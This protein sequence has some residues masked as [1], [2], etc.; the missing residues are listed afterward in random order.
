MPGADPAGGGLA[1][2]SRLGLLP[3]NPGGL[4]A[5][6]VA[7]VAWLGLVQ[8]IHHFRG[9]PT[10]QVLARIDLVIRLAVIAV[11]GG[12]GVASWMGHG[13][14]PV[15]WLAAK[16]VLFACIVAAGLT[17]RIL[18]KPFGP[19]FAQLL[20]EGSS[21]AVESTIRGCLARTRPFVVFIWFALIGAAWLGIAKP[22]LL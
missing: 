7:A 2:A 5:L 6:A 20:S 17:I 19:A 16:M 3:I 15:R 21:P 13:P 8:A 11:V 18:F 10:A 9:S 22:A 1:L 14:V 12:L 4:A